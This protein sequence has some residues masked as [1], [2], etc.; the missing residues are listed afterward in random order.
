MLVQHA[1][2]TDERNWIQLIGIQFL[3]SHMDFACWTGNGWN[4]CAWVIGCTL[5]SRSWVYTGFSIFCSS[6]EVWRL[7]LSFLR[8]KSSRWAK[9]W[10][11]FLCT[12]IWLGWAWQDT[13]GRRKRSGYL[14]TIGPS[15]TVVLEFLE[16]CNLARLEGRMCKAKSV[17]LAAQCFGMFQEIMRKLAGSESWWL[18]SEYLLDSGLLMSMMF[19]MSYSDW[20][21]CMLLKN[22]L[23]EFTA[24]AQEGTVWK[25]DFWLRHCG[26]K[27]PAS[28]P[29]VLSRGH[30]MAPKRAPKE[31]VDVLARKGRL[32]WNSLFGT[33]TLTSLV[34]LYTLCRFRA[35]QKHHFEGI[36]QLNL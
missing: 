6:F 20:F 27:S 15:G 29:V 8:C 23:L 4:G 35:L 11:G 31:P 16:L 33:F 28:A 5:P 34:Q 26:S 32:S 9:G 14:D 30:T 21:W 19:V 10:W 7:K 2:T 17:E 12:W 1:A 24:T 18:P 22:E 13:I 25:G 3:T 36:A